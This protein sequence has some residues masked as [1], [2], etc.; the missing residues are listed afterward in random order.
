VTYADV[1]READRLCR[2]SVGLLHHVDDTFSLNLDDE[3][4]KREAFGV[5]SL[6]IS[7]ASVSQFARSRI[8]AHWINDRLHLD[9]D[10]AGMEELAELILD[11]LTETGR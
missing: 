9:T 1:Q 2:E 3:H 4:A 5:A 10:D 6:V 7:L 8:L 11:W